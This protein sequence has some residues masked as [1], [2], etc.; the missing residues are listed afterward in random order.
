LVLSIPSRDPDRRQWCSAVWELYVH[1]SLLNFGFKVRPHPPLAHTARRIDFLAT[2]GVERVYIE[3]V[4]LG[5]PDEAAARRQ[6]VRALLAAVD[7]S[8]IYNFW[9]SLVVLAHGAEPIPAER[10]VDELRRWAGVLDVEDEAGTPA[11]GGWMPEFIWDREGWRVRVSATPRSPGF[12]GRSDMRPLAVLPTD[13]DKEPTWVAIREQL[14]AKALAYGEL[15]APFVITANAPE[16][17]PDDEDKEWAALG[18]YPFESAWQRDGFLT[19][20]DGVTYPGVSGV[21]VATA[22]QEHSFTSRAPTLYENPTARR[23]V[24]DEL[25][26]ARV[27][28]DGGSVIRVPGIDP[29]EMF[30]LPRDWPGVPWPS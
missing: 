27:R 6:R 1:E 8:Q 17:W 18:P 23:R 19:R 26:W 4:T 30:A 7:R 14:E 29:P 25:A 9:L 16:R 11:R 28:I 24:P 20:N 12:R 15:D 3:C 21:L 13:R 10:F 22:I 5:Y 2:K